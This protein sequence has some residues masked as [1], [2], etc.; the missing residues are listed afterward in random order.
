M[1]FS[2]SSLV[3]LVAVVMFSVS[4]NGFQHISSSSSASM[5]KTMT[6]N[7][8]HTSTA[9]QMGARN[10]AWAKG[11]LS[12][13]DIFDEG[14][15]DSGKSKKEKFKLEP[16]TVFFEGPPS[17]TEVLFPALSIVT[18]IGIVPFISALSRQ[19]W[20]KYKFTSRR[21]SIQSGFG[22]KDQSEIIYPDIEE[23]RFAYRAFG[24]AG[25]MVLFLKDGAKVELR[26]VPNFTE[27]YEYV[28]SKCD[29]EAKEKS[30]KIKKDTE[31]SVEATVAVAVATSTSETE[32]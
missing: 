22:G 14:D 5:L 21:I 31:P 4:C 26:H 6:R 29:D 1:N 15:G 8:I 12:D 28:I 7:K 9:L 13:K 3:S 17:A 32:A 18:V 30:M 19:F 16:E 11:D 24:S 2:F 20:V 23:I 10:R 27:I 25:D